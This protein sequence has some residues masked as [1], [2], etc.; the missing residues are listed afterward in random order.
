MNNKSLFAVVV[1]LLIGI[2]TVLSINAGNQD[3]NFSPPALANAGD[4]AERD[5]GP[6]AVQNN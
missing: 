4:Q 2:V 5:A 1:I 6:Q 3:L